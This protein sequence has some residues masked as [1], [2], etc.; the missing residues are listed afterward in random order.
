L[1]V[2]GYRA[3]DEASLAR[4][5]AG[6]FGE[7][8][9]YW[10]EYYKQGGN[11]RVELELVRLIEEDGDVR[12]SAAVLP[13]EVFVD[14]RPLPMGGIAAVATDP[15]YRR[16]G[17]AGELM[18]D[19]LRTMREREMHL[20]LL[21][22]FAQVFY[23]AYGW[24][25]ATETIAYTLKPTDLPTSSEQRRVRAYRERDLPEMMDLLEGEA[26]G[27]SCCVR[28]SEGRWRSLVSRKD[29][30]AAVYEREGR[31]EGYILYRMSDWR[32]RKPRRTLS[33]RELV[34]STVGAWRALISFLAAQDP[35]VFEIKHSTPRG[36]PLHPYL[37]NSY[38]K[39]EIVPEFM[40]RLVDVQGA[41][42]YLSCTPEAP[43][44]LEVS[45]DVIAENAGSY[46][47]GNGEVVRGEEAEARVSLD[48]RQLA[49]L[50][51]GYLPAGQ[52][53]R[54]GLVKPGSPEA[55]EL[56]EA[57]F[58]VDDPW[59]YPPDHF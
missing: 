58:P 43:L 25:L 9:G 40:L 48:V 19:V 10:K 45:D 27:R 6:A 33:V 56:L 30:Q 23:R 57:L 14:G 3:G 41:L 31:L 26:A 55:L 4:L 38:V 15:A 53:A 51:A 11:G 16:R 28:R 50:Y 59:V 34:W 21:H 7:N 32:D 13:L 35:L 47:V 42:S 24:E 20:S 36:E 5:G 29:W 22:P 39:A 49:Q 1:E 44:A 12:A 52:L 8:G 17:F 18:R 2:R 46:T 37:R 54:H